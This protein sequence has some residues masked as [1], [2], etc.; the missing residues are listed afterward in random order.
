MR[1]RALTILQLTHQGGASGST[2]MIASLSRQ[3][4]RRGHRVLG[5]SPPGTSLADLPRDAGLDVVPLDFHHLSPLSR[6]LDAVLARERVEVV[7]SNATR[8]RRALPR[9]RG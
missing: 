2:V 3:L 8:D 1:D 6:A 7:N 5:G 4:A 9:L